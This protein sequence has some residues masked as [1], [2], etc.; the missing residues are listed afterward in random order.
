MFFA[1]F[2]GIIADSG[3]PEALGWNAMI[4]VVIAFIITFVRTHF[5]WSNLTT[6]MIILG[7]AL[8]FHD[9][10]YFLIFNLSGQGSLF[11]VTIRYTLPSALYTIALGAGLYFWLGI[12]APK[13][14]V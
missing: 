5:D 8:L 7:F 12:K 14:L 6:Q 13:T 1:F 10:L 2:W 4:Y 11:F 3:S 9:I